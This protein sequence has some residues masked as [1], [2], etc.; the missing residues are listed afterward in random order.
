[1]NSLLCFYFQA[2]GD[3][4]QKKAELLQYIISQ[5]KTRKRYW[6]RFLR[7]LESSDHKLFAWYLK[8]TEILLE[9]NADIDHK[10]VKDCEFA[11]LL[12]YKRGCSPNVIEC[13]GMGVL[14]NGINTG[15]ISVRV[16]LVTLW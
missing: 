12:C 13:E 1:M 8:K 10:D 9:G 7:Y 16:A 5:L 11:T 14:A 15:H 6:E 2:H 3:L 4:L